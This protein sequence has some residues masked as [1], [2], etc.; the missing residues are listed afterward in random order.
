MTIFIVVVGPLIKFI[1]SFNILDWFAENF[2]PFMAFMF[3]LKK[4]I[5]IWA[6]R[7]SNIKNIVFNL[8]ILFL[9]QI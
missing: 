7:Q 5:K 3:F 2:D 4:I 8:P 6:W 1:E 9:K